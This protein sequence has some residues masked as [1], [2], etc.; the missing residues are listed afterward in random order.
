MS[1][2]IEEYITLPVVSDEH[3]CYVMDSKSC[4]VIQIIAEHL[5]DPIQVQLGNAF[6]VA[7]NKK[8]HVKGKKHGFDEDVIRENVP[9]PVTS[10]GKGEYIRDADGKEVMLVRGWGR[11]QYLGEGVAINAQILI[12]DTFA[13]AFNGMFPVKVLN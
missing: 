10:D 6:A 7:L 5:S 9:L 8:L 3:G 1:K 4:M 13:E 12:G 2:K 11:L